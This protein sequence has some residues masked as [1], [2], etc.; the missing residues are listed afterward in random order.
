M[1]KYLAVSVVLGTLFTSALA[2]DSYTIDSGFAM[3]SFDIPR[4]AFSSQRG[5]FKKTSGK[6][7][8]DLG[9]KKEV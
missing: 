3:A 6:V 4:V 8:L 9:A 5:L 1:K 7:V 2:A